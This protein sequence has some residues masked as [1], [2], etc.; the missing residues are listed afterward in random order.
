MTVVAAGL[1]GKY[2]VTKADGEPTDP[3]AR[4]FVMRLDTDPH[5]RRAAAA[6]ADE[7]SQENPELAADLLELLRSVKMR[8]RSRTIVS[9]A[10]TR[11]DLRRLAQAARI[12]VEHAPE[13]PQQRIQVTW[14]FARQVELILDQ[15]ACFRC[16]GRGR[17]ADTEEGTSACP[18]CSGMGFA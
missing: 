7:V 2:V 15:I 6:Y 10:L 8:E 3:S 14:P 1:Y 11:Y 5:A 13:C 12:L 16:R 18:N 9:K 17:I 4:Y